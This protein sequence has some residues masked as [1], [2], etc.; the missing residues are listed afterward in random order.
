VVLFCHPYWK[1]RGRRMKFLSFCEHCMPIFG[2]QMCKT[3]WQFWNMLCFS[4]CPLVSWVGYGRYLQN[5]W[6]FCKFTS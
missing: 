4:L 5:W 3:D 1:I 2:K 6:Q